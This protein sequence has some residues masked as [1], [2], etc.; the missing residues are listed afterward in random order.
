MMTSKSLHEHMLSKIK[1]QH[2]Y[3]LTP[4]YE[5]LYELVQRLIPDLRH[6][7]PATTLMLDNE[8]QLQATID[9]QEKYTSLLTFRISFAP[10]SLPN[11]TMKI[12][13]YHDAQVAE[14]VEYQGQGYLLPD[15]VYPNPAGFHPDEKFQTNL[16]LKE[17]LIHFDHLGIELDYQ[18]I[19]V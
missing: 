1:K 15:Y 8:C 11:L 2:F 3:H 6:L 19:T 13:A 5:Q 12:R 17:W 18:T 7:A 9:T 16:L 10:E 4:L 14:A